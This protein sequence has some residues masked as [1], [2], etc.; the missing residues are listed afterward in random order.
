[1]A[2]S[3]FYTTVCHG[4]PPCDEASLQGWKSRNGYDG[5]S[6]RD[7]AIR[8]DALISR[9]LPEAEH[10]RT[11]WRIAGSRSPTSAIGWPLPRPGGLWL[12]P[13]GCGRCPQ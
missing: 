11:L 4:P 10:G 9:A 1:M 6:P 2:L 7:T 3:N 8:R 13:E 5:S 12:T